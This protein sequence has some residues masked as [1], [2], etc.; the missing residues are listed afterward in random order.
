MVVAKI[1]EIAFWGN[2][3]LEFHEF[4]SANVTW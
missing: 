1:G 3:V 2:E 4:Y